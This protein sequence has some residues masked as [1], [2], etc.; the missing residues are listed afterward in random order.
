M[1]YRVKPYILLCLVLIFILWPISTWAQDGGGDKPQHDPLGGATEFP[2]LAEKTPVTL[3]LDWTPN[4]NHLGIYV[5]LSKGYYEEANLELT[6][7]EPTDLTPETALDAG[8]VEFGIGF[9]EFTSLAMAE[10]LDVVSV[11][12]IIQHNT[13]GFASIATE[14]PLNSP[15]DLVGLTYG[16]FSFPDLENPILHLLTSCDNASWD[17]ADY[18]DVGFT[19]PIELLTRNRIDVAWIF[20]GWQGIRAEVEGIAL[21]VLFLQDYPDC[22]PDYYTPI[23]LTTRTLIEEQPELVA[24]FV[25]ATARGYADAIQDPAGA[26]QILLEAVPELDEKLVMASAEWLAPQ[27][28]ADAL[29][30]GQQDQEVWEAFTQFLIDNGLI[31]ELDVERVF[32]NEFLPGTVAD[33]ANTD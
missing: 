2:R 32:T 7:I 1:G 20:Y 26:A 3:M 22:V 8:L 18:L 24:S 21:D 15:A 28:Q 11:A 4:T 30:W 14:H 10:G 12:A 33:E 31:A 23:L 19:D 29:R 6:I 25:Q 17:E 16:G 5:A 9:Q 27:Y 13:S